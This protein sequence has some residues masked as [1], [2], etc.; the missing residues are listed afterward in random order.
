MNLLK[1][2]GEK[3][4][5]NAYDGAHVELVEDN[6]WRLHVEIGV[7]P[8]GTYENAL[9]GPVTIEETDATFT[10]TVGNVMYDGTFGMGEGQVGLNYTTEGMAY[11]GE[12]AQLVCKMI[13]NK[14]GLRASGSEQGMQGT[15][16]ISLDVYRDKLTA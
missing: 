2:L 7:I 9:W 13:R 12:L 11:G 10:V 6:L 1:V 3:G 5:L 15:D 8:S 16:Y 14:T 4:L